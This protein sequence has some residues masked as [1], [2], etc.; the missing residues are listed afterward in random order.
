[1][2]DLPALATVLSEGT[3]PVH[4]GECHRDAGTEVGV[5]QIKSNPCC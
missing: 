1:M 4:G 3:V 2:A 5:N